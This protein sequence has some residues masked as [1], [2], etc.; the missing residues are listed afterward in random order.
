LRL[1]RGILAA[2]VVLFFVALYAPIAVLV[3]LS[4]NEGRTPTVWEGFS[5]RWFAAVF[6]DERYTVPFGN[7]LWIGIITTFL[8]VVLGTLAGIAVARRPPG[9]FSFAWDALILMPLIIP[10]IIEAL[11]IQ[12]FYQVVGIPNGVLAT[13][14]GHTVFSVSFVALIVRARMGDLGKAYEEA[15]M[16][17]GAGRVQTF[18]RVLLPLAAPAVIAGAFLAFA[19]SW[20]DVV[21]SQF[22]TSVDSR[23]LPLVVFAAA[24]RGRISPLLNALAVV[25]VIISFSAAIMRTLAE[26]RI[27]RT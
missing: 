13:V 19:S 5:T 9:R 26:R 11:S 10:E 8:S 21:K 2:Y 23:T 16:I 4:F 14:L 22:T 18:V 1:G 7:S 24:A 12:L 17:L 6:D 15:S 27:G 3:G 25:M 20:D